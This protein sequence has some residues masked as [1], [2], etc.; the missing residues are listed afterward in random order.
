[1]LFDSPRIS[2]AKSETPQAP[3]HRRPTWPTRQTRP[4]TPHVT[5]RARTSPFEVL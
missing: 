2:I 3:D 5:L 4:K 1:M